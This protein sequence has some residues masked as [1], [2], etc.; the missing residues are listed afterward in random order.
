MSANSTITIL[1]NGERR[2]LAPATH[3]ARLLEQ[4]DLSGQRLAVEVNE[5]IVPR[6]Q[7]AQQLLNDGDRVEIVRAVGGG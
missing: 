4:L 5:H 3:I 6:S 7:H 1:L 2:P